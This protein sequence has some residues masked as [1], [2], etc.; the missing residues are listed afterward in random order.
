M[1]HIRNDILSDAM[2]ISVYEQDNLQ[3]F[4]YRNLDKSET[5]FPTFLPANSSKSNDNK[6]G[7]V[8]LPPACLGK[9]AVVSSLNEFQR[10]FEA[11]TQNQLKYINWEN[12][13]CAGT[14]FASVHPSFLFT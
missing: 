7:W 2:L 13:V 11:F 8:P 14:L 1:L 12:V 9:P 5:A 10:N 3:K 4:K 6:K